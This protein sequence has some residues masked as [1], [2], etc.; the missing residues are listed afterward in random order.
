MSPLKK[1]HQEARRFLEKIYAQYDGRLLT[2]D[3]ISFV[4]R[5]SD[6]EDQEI[7][8]FLS[9]LLAFGNVGA[10]QNSLEKILSPLGPQPARFIRTAQ[11][12]EILAMKLPQHRWVRESD[13]HS[14]LI[15]LRVIFHKE[16]SL[17]RLFLKGYRPKDPNL[18]STLET[19]C[20]TLSSLSPQKKNSKGFQ[21]FFPLPSR[22][23]ACKRLHMFLR[24]MVR[25]DDGIDLGLWREIPPSKLIVPLDTHLYQF[26]RKYHLS[27]LKTANGKMAQEV[28]SFL[29]ELDPQD[30]VKYDFAICHYGMEK[31]YR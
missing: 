21:Y 5:Y 27:R 8:A 22:G 19:F 31:G 23:S 16:G 11:D 17:K 13:L 1:D 3:P 24:W 2:E 25:P 7:V 4:H 18:L 29:R 14:L 9:S 10:I 6:S 15:L 20:Q 12:S 28:T 26:A 30:P